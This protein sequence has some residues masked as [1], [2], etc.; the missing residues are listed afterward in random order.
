MVWTLLCVAADI[1]VS[2]VAHITG[3]DN[4]AGKVTGC[5]VGNRMNSTEGND[6][7]GAPW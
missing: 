4:F 5:S 2:E 6:C 7:G 1:N 3:K